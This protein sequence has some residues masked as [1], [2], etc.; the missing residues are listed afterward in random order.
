M[1]HLWQYLE[2]YKILSNCWLAII[3]IAAAPR[4]RGAGELGNEEVCERGFSWTAKP[5]SSTWVWFCD[6]GFCID[7]PDD[8]LEAQQRIQLHLSQ[9]SLPIEVL[10][11]T[12]SHLFY[13]TNLRIYFFP[14]FIVAL[15]IPLQSLV[16]SQVSYLLTLIPH[17]WILQLDCSY[18]SVLYEEKTILSIIRVHDEVHEQRL[19]RKTWTN[20]GGF[21][22]VILKLGFPFWKDF[23]HTVV[24]FVCIC[25]RRRWHSPAEE[26]ICMW[27]VGLLDGIVSF[28]RAGMT[29]NSYCR[30][31]LIW[32]CLGNTPLGVSLGAVP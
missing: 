7:D 11:S 19:G 31:S 27:E 6:P 15:F 17:F 16:S 29:G 26:F 8:P 1:R 9:V 12:M 30:P 24:W 32:N 14:R 22:N 13:V 25:D 28:G 3:V 5:S 23:K 20:C 2:N 21:C 10:T 4:R 18:F